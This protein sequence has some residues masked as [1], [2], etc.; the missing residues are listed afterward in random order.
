MD[1]RAT[2]TAVGDGSGTQ[3]AGTQNEAGRGGDVGGTSARP[4]Y[5]VNPKPPY[6]MLARRR[7]EQGTVLLRVLVRADGHVAEAEVKQ[8]SGSALL[9]DVALRTVRSTWRFTPAR[10]NGVPVESWVEVP[11]RFVLEDA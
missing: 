9:D 1:G 11:I 2:S 5:S 7:G 8:S 4:D 3:A 10:L 6:P